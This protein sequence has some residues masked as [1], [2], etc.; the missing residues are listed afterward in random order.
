MKCDLYT[1]KKTPKDYRRRSRTRDVR[2]HFLI[3]CEGRKTEPNYFR[4]FRI[5]TLQVEI[6][7]LGANTKSLIEATIDKRSEGIRRGRKYNQTWCVFDR[8]SFPK[9]SF[10][11]AFEAAKNNDIRI[12]YSNEAFELW[13]VLHFEYLQSALSRNDYVRKLKKLLGRK[14]QKND[15]DMYEE[16]IEKQLVAAE[17]AQKLL[18]SYADFDPERNNPST[19]VHRLVQE[20]NRFVI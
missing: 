13:Y 5:S 6:H 18:D 19:T 10:N 16:L 4:C 1:R 3:V 14:Y 11:D 20:L 7:G 9:Q 12:A 17:T 2:D 8:D 15:P